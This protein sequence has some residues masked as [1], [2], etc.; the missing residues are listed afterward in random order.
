VLRWSDFDIASND[1]GLAIDDFTI[2]AGLAVGQMSSGGT[3]TGGGTGGGTGTVSNTSTSTP[4]FENK[5]TSDTV[6]FLTLYGNLHGHSTHSDGR[7][8][9]LEPANDYE[10]ARKAAGMDFLG[11]SEHNHATAGLQ[12]AN[13][14]KGN[15]QA[16][17]A[18]GKLNAAGKTFTALHGMEW[19]TISGGG[20]VIVYGMYDT[21]IGWEPNN[22]DVFVQKSDY[23]ALFERIRRVPW[24][25]ATLAHP[26]TTDFTGLTGGYK[27]VADSAVSS[28]A[29]ESGPAFSTSTT[30][31]NFPAS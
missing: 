31:D 29:I 13:Y 15:Y 2:S 30:Y 26:N 24:A 9:T 11:I 16:D 7:P 8:S 18:N 20:H 17:T 14:H 22:Y 21:L 19:G 4:I 27:G 10:Y 1:D 23:M 3:T 5:V 28:V 6:P 25:I 12:I